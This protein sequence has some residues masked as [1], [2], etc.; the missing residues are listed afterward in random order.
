VI[1]K[2][3]F[4][5]IGHEK[6]ISSKQRTHGQKKKLARQYLE[7]KFDHETSN[8]EV[9]NHELNV[10]LSHFKLVDEKKLKREFVDRMSYVA[11]LIQKNGAL[12]NA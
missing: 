8:I 11:Q 5:F 10:L 1:P 6:M 12:K 2:R 4:D 3:V 7:R 9:Y